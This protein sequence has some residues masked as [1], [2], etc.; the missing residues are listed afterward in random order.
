MK[1]LIRNFTTAFFILVLFNFFGSASVS[2]NVDITGSF[3]DPNFLAA[4][5]DELNIPSGPIL[6]SDVAQITYLDVSGRNITNMAG[7]HHFTALEYLYCNNNRLSSIDVSSN[8]VLRTLDVSRNVFTS[9]NVMMNSNLEFLDISWN[10]LNG[11]DVSAVASFPNNFIIDLRYNRMESVNDVVG[12]QRTGLI[13]EDTLLFHP[14]E[15]S[16]QRNDTA[17]EIVNLPIG[18]SN[19]PYNQPLFERQW[20]G[21]EWVSGNLPS[22]LFINLETGFISGTTAQTGTY[23]FTL[24]ISTGETGFY[25]IER[26]VT[27][28]LQIEAGALRPSEPVVISRPAFLFT[29]Y[30]DYLPRPDTPF[31]F[32]LL[33]FL[34]S[35]IYFNALTGEV[36]G[37][38]QTLGQQRFNVFV[39]SEGAEPYTITYILDVTNVTGR[40]V[41]ELTDPGFEIFSIREIL[42][43][44]NSVTVPR[45]QVIELFVLTAFTNLE[46]VCAGAF[47]SFTDLY[48]N[49]EKL[50]PGRDYIADE[51][52]T[53]ITLFEHVFRN[54]GNREYYIAAE[55]RQENQNGTTDLFKGVQRIVVQVDDIPPDV[56]QP[57]Q[58]QQPEIV[59]EPQQPAVREQN[60]VVPEPIIYTPEPINVSLEPLVVAP[61]EPT[62]PAPEI[63]APVNPPVFGTVPKTGLQ[64]NTWL[65]IAISV[66]FSAFI[67]LLISSIYIIYKRGC[68]GRT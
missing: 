44:G 54:R 61:V 60:I 2:A 13:L 19:T 32:T 30:I 21:G 37:A 15:L 53:R 8:R 4:L 42:I 17:V 24:R 25:R 38:P 33:D 64:S 48:I 20:N 43:G 46:L 31:T 22:G 7:I 6:S 16:S 62:P 55:F 28:V 49:G 23:E 35:G 58:P 3:T 65:I 57:Q 47:R 26:T 14:Q 41:R 45:D 36:Y 63:V 9:F 68:N 50:M 34:P 66:S 59:R 40:T 12:W 51:S 39:T 1:K 27:Y 10:Q 56:Q 11:F 29:P 5:R 52:S 18:N 67:I